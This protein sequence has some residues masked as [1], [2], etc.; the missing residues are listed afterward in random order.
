[1]NKVAKKL[2]LVG[3][4]SLIASNC[5]RIWV[6]NGFNEVVLIGRDRKRLENV[7]CDLAVRSGRDDFSCSCEVVCDGTDAESVTETI[8]NICRDA[9]P[10]IVLIAQGS[11]LDMNEE[12][13]QNLSRLKSSLLLNGISPVLYA[14]GFARHM[15]KKGAGH[16]VM[17]GSVAGDR[18]RSSNYVYGSGKSLLD[19]YAEGM[20]HYFA[21]KKCGV[22]VTVVKP[23]PTLTPMTADLVGKVKLAD[24]KDVAKCIVRGVDCGKKT[25]YAPSRWRLIMFVIRNLPS[26]VFNRLN[27]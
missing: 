27:I 13:Q 18:G 22:M 1:M 12:L 5:A 11:S 7:G 21:L 3:A 4:T 24:V 26:F 19:T 9:V 14:Q 23:G 2:V 25:V 16:V 17:I 20:R 15:E 8:D 6:Q 10:D